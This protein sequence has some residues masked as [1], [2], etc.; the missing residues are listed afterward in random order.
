M[1]EKDILSPCSFFE[2]EEEE[3]AIEAVRPLGSEGHRIADKGLL[4]GAQ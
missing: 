1:A 4:N 2:E 3:E